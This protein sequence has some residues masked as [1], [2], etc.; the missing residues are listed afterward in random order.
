MFVEIGRVGFGFRLLDLPKSLAYVEVDGL[1]SV[2]D[3]PKH[4]SDGPVSIFDQ[5]NPPQR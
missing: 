2:L 1:V 5:P 3:Q 4:Y